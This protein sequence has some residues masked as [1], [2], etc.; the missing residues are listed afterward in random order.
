MSKQYNTDYNIMRGDKMSISHMLSICF[1]CDFSH[2]CTDYRSTFRR[3]DTD[4]SEEDT[5]LRHIKYYY[6]SR[7]LYEAIEFFGSI[8]SKNQEPVYH[9]LNQ[10]FLFKDVSTNF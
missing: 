5:T 1:Y 3:M 7:F 2:M 4:N 8:R 10:Q 9:G 6:F